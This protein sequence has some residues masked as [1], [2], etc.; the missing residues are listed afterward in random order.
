MSSR[1]KATCAAWLA[2]ALCLGLCASTVSAQKKG[3]KARAEPAPASADAPS[4]SP[5]SADPVELAPASDGSAPPPASNTAPPSGLS[6]Q[7]AADSSASTAEPSAAASAEAAAPVDE[8]KLEEARAVREDLSGVMDALVSARARAALLGKSLFK[9][10]IRVLLENDAADDQA[11]GK[12][13]LFLD[14]NPIF[15]GEGSALNPEG[16]KLF[17]GYAAPGPHVLTVEVEQR[18]RADDG[19][20]YTQTSALRFTVLREKL[21]AL[22]LVLDDDSDIAEDFKDDEE[23]EYDVRLRLE[24]E[25]LPLGG[26]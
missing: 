11:L 25:A 13:A 26:S 22:K 17:E 19:Y 24:V 23:G 20:S 15:R 9:T 12:V 4:P 18:A 5:A 16:A 7:P 14:G 2:A 10:R 3:R 6:I 1:T 21:T 8:G